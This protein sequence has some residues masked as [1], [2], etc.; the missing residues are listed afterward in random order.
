MKKLFDPMEIHKFPVEELFEDAILVEALSIKRSS[1]TDRYS[2]QYNDAIDRGYC[3][4]EWRDSEIGIALML[5]PTQKLKDSF[6]AIND[7]RLMNIRITIVGCIECATKSN[8]SHYTRIAGM[9]CLED[10]SHF[11]SKKK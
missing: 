2:E 11:I 1:V 3:F 10:F 5:K 8:E 6:E 4:S 9:I 7:S